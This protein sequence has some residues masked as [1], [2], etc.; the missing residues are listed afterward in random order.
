MGGE[1]ELGGMTAT[2]SSIPPAGTRGPLDAKT[3]RQKNTAKPVIQNRQGDVKKKKNT[4]VKKPLRKR[5]VHRVKPNNSKSG[6]VTPANLQN[7]GGVIFAAIVTLN[8]CKKSP[9]RRIP[10]AAKRRDVFHPRPKSLSNPSP[11]IFTKKKLVGRWNLWVMLRRT[12][13]ALQ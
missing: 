8:L 1:A 11:D 6:A 5:K 10:E 3:G 9:Y 12:C 2:L 13:S 4:K 7:T